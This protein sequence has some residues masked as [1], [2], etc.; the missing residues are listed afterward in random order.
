[1]PLP[2]RHFLGWTESAAL[3]VARW[4]YERR[5]TLATNQSGVLDFTNT[6]V[7]VP[8]AGAR[9]Q[10]LAALRKII[11]G[12]MIPPSMATPGKFMVNAFETPAGS[13]VA[14]PLERLTAICKAL[15][16]NN[17]LREQLLPNARA[18]T[19]AALARPAKRL[20]DVIDRADDAHKSVAEISRLEILHN[21]PSMARSWENLAQLH[22][23]MKRELQDMGALVNVRM[24]ERSDVI[25]LADTA[26]W[27]PKCGALVL[28]GLPDFAR[29]VSFAAESL[30]NAQFNGQP[31]QVHALVLAPASEAAKF[32][33]LGVVIGGDN[34]FTS[35]PDIHDNMIEVAGDPA[36]QAAAT[37]ARYCKLTG[38][39]DTGDTCIVLADESLL[40][41]MARAFAQHGRG[42]HSGGGIAFVQTEVGQCLQRLEAATSGGQ[43]SQLIEFIRVPAITRGIIM[44]GDTSGDNFGETVIDTTIQ[45]PIQ[46]LER[47]L[48]D[49]KATSIEQ[50]W[51]Q[52]KAKNGA[53]NLAIALENQFKDWFACMSPAANEKRPLG[54]RWNQLQEWI[55]CQ[56]ASNTNPI[57]TRACLEC[58]KALQRAQESMAALELA[59]APDALSI[60]LLLCADISVPDPSDGQNVDTVG[61]LET[62]FE[63]CKKFVLTG[64][65]EGSLP[66]A[67]QVDGWLNESIRAAIGLPTRGA[68]FARDAYLL[69][70]L[71]ARAHVA[72]VNAAHMGASGLAIIAGQ[73]GGDGEPLKPSRL[74]L[75]KDEIAI[76]HRI[77]LLL[78][79]DADGAAIKRMRPDE[80]HSAAFCSAFSVKPQPRAE[81][82]NQ[83]PRAISVTDFAVHIDNPYRYWLEKV[84]KLSAPE[85]DQ[86]EL[87]AAEFG[88]LFHA[89][90]QSLN[91]PTIQ[92][93]DFNNANDEKQCV[94]EMMQVSHALAQKSYGVD[95]TLPIRLALLELHNRLP[96]LVAWHAA[97]LRAGWRIVA[98]EWPSKY[99]DATAM[100]DVDGSMQAIKFRVDRI[101]FHPNHG[102]RIIDYKSSD[103][104]FVVQ[105]KGSKVLRGAK[106]FDLQLPLYKFLLPQ[107]AAHHADLSGLATATSDKIEVG[108][109]SVPASNLPPQWC[110]LLEPID[111]AIAEAKRIVRE[112]RAGAFPDSGR[113]PSGKFERVRRALCLPMFGED[114]DDDQDTDQVTDQNSDQDSEG[115][116]T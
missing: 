9:R 106:W 58:V 53:K 7:I 113:D 91:T 65:F 28:A 31:T 1:M 104:G 3:S 86:V 11:Q 2:E 101:D 48:V 19:L 35:G 18:T 102:W 39:V 109:L 67:A 59:S 37:V 8:G 63:P 12:A 108:V 43:A 36:D 21:S 89:A 115:S 105:G 57:T 51:P 23:E 55:S 60:A 72:N 5:D 69:S 96:A 42:V 13:V 90:A 49:C 25:D 112:I 15:A 41:N 38:A 94:R 20:L 92:S 27:K 95:L 78:P 54:A 62:L 81:N 6:L 33:H 32:D 88:T 98:T 70:A 17:A 4:L 75:P 14:G 84:L 64:V 116:A 66:S 99:E 50:F 74:L 52:L 93:L 80:A 85:L 40:P 103:G 76:A 45:S 46:N 68:R 44:D 107:I 111:G 77:L 100:L 34:G 24:L 30:A 26:R 71:V 56:F 114:S 97:Q 10:V 82:K 79:H 73:L 29:N 47:L 61:W 110:P 87:N 83:M 16:K 22:A